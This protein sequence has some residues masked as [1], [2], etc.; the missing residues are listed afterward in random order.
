[1]ADCSYS[2]RV[3]EEF[4]NKPLAGAMVVVGS[5]AVQTDVNGNFSLTADCG[6]QNVKVMLKD[7]ETYTAKPLIMNFGVLQVK[8]KPIVKPLRL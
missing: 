4:S 3:I 2:G 1:M 7:H 6:F 5:K 8:L